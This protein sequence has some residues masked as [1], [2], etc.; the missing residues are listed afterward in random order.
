MAY[1]TWEDATAC[2]KCGYTGELEP[3]E[4]KQVAV[5]DAAGKRIFGV[6]PGAK[7][8]KIY[9]RNSRCRW[10]DTCWTV[11]VNPDG[12]IPDPEEH[13]GPK[14]YTPLDPALAAQMKANF[15]SLHEATLRGT[16]NTGEVRNR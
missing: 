2:P 4:S 1:G 13:R 16:S 11:Q 7:L 12:S 6:T 10:F 14:Q 15:E 5:R 3:R 8:H 9:C